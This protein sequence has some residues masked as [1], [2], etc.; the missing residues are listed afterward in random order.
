MN[1]EIIVLFCLFLYCSSTTEDTKLLTLFGYGSDNSFEFLEGY[2]TYYLQGYLQNYKQVEF[3]ITSQRSLAQIK[4]LF[5]NR[6]YYYAEDLGLHMLNDALPSLSMVGG[7]YEY[8]FTAKASYATRNLIIAVHINSPSSTYF[9]VYVS[10]KY[11]TTSVFVNILIGIGLILLL[12]CCI[13]ICKATGGSA[14]EGIA[15]CLA[16]VVCC[17]GR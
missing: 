7:N 1:K 9:N 3:K 12:A 6:D 2:R 4:Y 15:A 16:V 17:C 8:T 13:V 10:S 11:P 5:T 14:L